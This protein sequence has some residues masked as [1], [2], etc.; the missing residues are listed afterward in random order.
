M[1][2][3][4]LSNRRSSSL[5]NDHTHPSIMLTIEPRTIK[6]FSTHFTIPQ[7]ST[8]GEGKLGMGEVKTMTINIDPLN[9]NSNPHQGRRQ[10]N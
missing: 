6:K 7:K 5:L 4:S 2:T 3:S 10:P 8:E 9:S 1:N